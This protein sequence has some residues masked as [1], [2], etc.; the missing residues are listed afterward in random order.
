[1]QYSHKKYIDITLCIV[2]IIV[3][4]IMGIGNKKL[5]GDNGEKGQT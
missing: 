5:S 1:L 2:E 4:S 3:Y